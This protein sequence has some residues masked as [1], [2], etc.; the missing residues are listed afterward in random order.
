[1]TAL[2]LSSPVCTPVVLPRRNSFVRSG[3]G[4]ARYAIVINQ[5]VEA[6]AFRVLTSATA[7]LYH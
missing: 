7:A 1:M 6:N 2:E 4:S 3:L 5:C